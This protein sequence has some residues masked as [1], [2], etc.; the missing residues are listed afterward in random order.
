[1]LT[2]NDLERERYEARLKMQR[3]ISTALAEARDEGL[4]RGRKEGQL[5]GQIHFCQRL[6]Q[7]PQSLLAARVSN[8]GIAA[9]VGG[10]EQPATDAVQPARIGEIGELDLSGN[11][12]G[13][14][15]GLREAN[16]AIGS[17]GDRLRL[18][19]DRDLDFRRCNRSGHSRPDCRHIDVFTFQKIQVGRIPI[20]RALYGT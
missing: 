10:Q 6:L 11:L 20:E 3:D 9:R 19:R 1:M 13:R 8:R 18:G 12:S 15:P 17:D 16:R 2:Q 4:E 14:L 5:V 7:R